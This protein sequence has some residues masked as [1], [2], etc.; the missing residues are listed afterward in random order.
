MFCAFLSHGNSTQTTEK[1]TV[2][3]QRKAKPFRCPTNHY[4][5]GCWSCRPGEGGV[6]VQR[7]LKFQYSITII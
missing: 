2:L 6:E 4:K 5:E 7:G 3:S 1:F